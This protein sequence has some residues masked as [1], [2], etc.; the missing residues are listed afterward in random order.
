MPILQSRFRLNTTQIEQ[1]IQLHTLQQQLELLLES[2]Q[3]QAFIRQAQQQLILLPPEQRSKY[4][5]QQLLNY[6]A[7]AEV[8]TMQL[9]R[10]YHR[11]GAPSPDIIAAFSQSQ[12]P[13]LQAQLRR[14]RWWQPSQ[15]PLHQAGGN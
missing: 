7:P 1:T 15:Q 3:W 8:L 5:L 14:L 12:N 13:K 2:E 6:Q 11:H 4:V 9:Q 10:H